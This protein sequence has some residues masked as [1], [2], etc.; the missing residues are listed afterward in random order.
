M[1]KRSRRYWHQY[2]VMNEKANRIVDQG[3]DAGW[4]MFINWQ[5]KHMHLP[6]YHGTKYRGRKRWLAKGKSTAKLTKGD[7]NGK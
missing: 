1:V 7:K 3:V 6:K 4:P 2:L 5:A